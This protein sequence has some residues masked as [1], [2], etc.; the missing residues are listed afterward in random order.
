VIPRPVVVLP[1]LGL[2]LGLVLAGR[3]LL[4]GGML[5][6]AG[7]RAR[8]LGEVS[9]EML[10]PPDLPVG[11]R[12]EAFSW[13][14]D[15]EGDAPVLEPTAYEESLGPERKKVLRLG[16]VPAPV[17]VLAEQQVLDLA[18]RGAMPRG[19]SRPASHYLPAGI[20]ILDGGGLGIGWFPG[21]RLIL[22]DEVPVTD[23]AEVVR[24]VLEGRA[25]REKVITATLARRTQGGVVTYRVLVDQPYLAADSSPVEAP[26]PEGAP[27][28]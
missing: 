8:T 19:V 12:R 25:R 11:P 16:P 7:E 24:R 2:V 1:L 27:E 23:R 15:P 21:D 22:V 10:P 6:R 20:E 5:A 18:A 14:L 17:V 26:A 28:P 9:S 4:V 13:L 3:Q